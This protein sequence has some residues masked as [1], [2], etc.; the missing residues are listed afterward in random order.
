MTFKVSKEQLAKRDALTADLRAKAE[1]L[2]V[3]ITA[4]NENVEQLSRPVAE[5]QADYNKTLEMARVLAEDIAED[6]QKEFDAKS[7]RW[8]ISER[9]EQ[10]REWIEQWEL[11]LEEV[12]LALPELLDE[13]DPE[14]HAVE[15]DDAMASPAE[16]E[17]SRAMTY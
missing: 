7:E 1:A 8:Q 3:A 13:I 11:G 5:A 6:A 4:F 9:G 2:N 15:L 10:V 17:H 12:E 16:L 14:E